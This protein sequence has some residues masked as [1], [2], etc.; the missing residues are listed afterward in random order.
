MMSLS[1]EG[2]SSG[3][4]AGTRHGFPAVPLELEPSEPGAVDGTSYSKRN[5]SSYHQS[6]LAMGQTPWWAQIILSL[7]L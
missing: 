2:P 4:P 3:I 6:L 1:Q 5:Q 7:I